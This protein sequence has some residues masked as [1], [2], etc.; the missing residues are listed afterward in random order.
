MIYIPSWWRW[1]P[2]ENVNVLKGNLKDLNDIP[3]CGLVD[4]FAHNIG[5]LPE[6]FHQTFLDGLR[7]HLPNHRVIRSSIRD[8]NQENR[9][10]SFPRFARGL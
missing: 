1:N 4:A 9:N 5:P 2:P 3:P 8:L 7:K 6:T 10:R